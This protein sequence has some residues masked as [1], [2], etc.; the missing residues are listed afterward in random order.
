MNNFIEINDVLMNINH[1]VSVRKMD[2]SNNVLYD[3][4][5]YSVLV[6][7]YNNTDYSEEFCYDYDNTNDRD[8]FYDEIKRNLENIS[9]IKK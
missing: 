8:K 6:T 4:S 9:V 3:D 5:V 1:I 7:L 2:N